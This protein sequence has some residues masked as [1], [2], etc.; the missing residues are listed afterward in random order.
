MQ[1]L[2]HVLVVAIVTIL[3]CDGSKS[4][5]SSR[6]VFHRQVVVGAPLV[7]LPRLTRCHQ[8]PSVALWLQRLDAY[9]CIHLGIISGTRRRNHIHALD[10]HR[11]QLFQLVGVA[12]LFIIDVY[13]RLTLC[14]YLKLSVLALHHGYHREQVVGTANI[15]QDR[16]LYLHR[17]ATRCTFVLRNLALHFHPLHHI[18]LGL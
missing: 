7:V 8:A 10:I 15:V 2:L 9:H 6:T 14:Q 3:E 4:L 5:Q 18:R 17:H 12:H 1:F 13:L 16:V 11:L